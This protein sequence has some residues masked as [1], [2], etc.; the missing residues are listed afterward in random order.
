[1]NHY[2]IV[3]DRSR[4]AIL[5]YEAF[6]TQQAALQAR[7]EAERELGHNSD[8]EVVV[9]GANSPEALRRT[10]SRYFRGLKQLF[11]SGLTEQPA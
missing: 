6:S 3:F 11:D 5:R 4:S 8:I 1:V 7:F 10:H 2:L 9:L